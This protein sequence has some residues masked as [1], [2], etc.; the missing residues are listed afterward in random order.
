MSESPRSSEAV[1]E[2]GLPPQQ[3]PDEAAAP[4]REPLHPPRKRHRLSRFWRSRQLRIR[5]LSILGMLVAWEGVSRWV[6]ETLVPGPVVTGEVL[7]RLAATGTLWDHFMATA[8]RVVSA[9]VLAM[10]FGVLIGTFMGLSKASEQ[11]LDL[12]VM[13]MLTIPGLCYIIV[14][15]MWFGINERSAVLAIMLTTLPAIAINIWSGVKAI[16]QRLT[17]MARAFRA[18]RT[19]RTAMVVLPQ[20]LPYTVAAM[21]YGLGMVWK[22]TVLVELLGRP[23]GVGYMLNH[24]FQVFNLPAVFAWTLFFV[25]VMLAVELLLLKPLE[26]RLFRWRPAAAA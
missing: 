13:V 17:D 24:S 1:S 10:I 26:Q 21:R 7:W 16:D 2:A 23:N 9:F 3:A 25:L 15:F 8:T 22:V 12:P 5:T 11:A 20:V 4:A 18:T 14:A 6:S 19:R